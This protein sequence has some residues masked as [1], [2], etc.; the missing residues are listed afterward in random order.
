MKFPFDFCLRR[1]KY[2]VKSK[3]KG[4][5][6]IP[7]GSKREAEK[8]YFDST[9]LWIFNI[10]RYCL[11]ISIWI[12]INNKVYPGTKLGFQF[13]FYFLNLNFRVML[14]DFLVLLG[15]YMFIAIKQQFNVLFV[16]I[17]KIIFINI[18]LYVL[19]IKT[20]IVFIG[21]QYNFLFSQITHWGKVLMTFG[22]I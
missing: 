12:L 8:P 5:N 10:L 2:K 4:I 15:K 6:F 11:W 3:L 7:V 20:I 19:I 9:Q 18:D 13:T 14:P 17:Y 1:W 21:I 16:F 22:T